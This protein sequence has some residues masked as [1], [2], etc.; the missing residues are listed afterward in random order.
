[1]PVRLNRLLIIGTFFNVTKKR[2]LLHISWNQWLCGCAHVPDVRT[3][4]CRDQGGW[5][6]RPLPGASR[7]QTRPPPTPY[8][9][10]ANPLLPSAPVCSA[11]YCRVVACVVTKYSAQ[12]G[13]LQPA[14]GQTGAPRDWSQHLLSSHFN[15]VFQIVPVYFFIVSYYTYRTNGSKNSRGAT[16]IS[17]ACCDSA[18]F[19]M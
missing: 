6:T 13:P 10:T 17:C 3:G 12:F 18:I 1:M 9:A 8:L 11:E 14:A 15:L 4:W 2:L 7:A 5:A 19:H 16:L